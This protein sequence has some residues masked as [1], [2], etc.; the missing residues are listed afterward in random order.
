MNNE[1]FSEGT[2][3]NGRTYSVFGKSHNGDAEQVDEGLFRVGQ[4]SIL[5]LPE[6]NVAAVFDGAGGA[7]DVGSPEVAA[8]QAA[9]EI[10]R[11]FKAGGA[12]VRAAVE[13]A[14]KAVINNPAAGVCVVALLRMRKGRSEIVNVGDTGV[15]G[16]DPM[17]ETTFI[18]EQ[19][20]MHNNP[21]N[22]LGRPV[23]FYEER[24]A[25]DFIVHQY[26]SPTEELYLMTDG[27]L[28]N[29]QNGTSLEDYHFQAARGDYMLLQAAFQANPQ[30]EQ[31]IVSFNGKDFNGSEL[32]SIDELDWA[33]WEKYVRPYI[34]EHIHVEVA[35]DQRSILCS[36]VER[37]ISW[38]FERQREDDASIIQISEE[39]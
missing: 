34:L 39:I 29:W 14:R 37:P 25:D 3:A 28:G 1:L 35:A 16:F 4:D 11:Y 10:S 18:V 8:L 33:T 21:S 19:Q 20:T 24:V 15:I 22:Y 6:H 36:L 7:T 2:F 13:S 12:D 23:R 5:V 9:T 30:L 27:A 17:G 32:F 31:A 26:A 38:N